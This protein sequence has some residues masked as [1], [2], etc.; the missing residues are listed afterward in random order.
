MINEDWQDAGTQ[1]FLFFLFKRIIF[2]V[3][4]CIDYFFSLKNWYLYC[5][6]LKGIHYPL[7][8]FV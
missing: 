8:R 1:Y 3:S 5:T 2:L 4:G 7:Y 6:S